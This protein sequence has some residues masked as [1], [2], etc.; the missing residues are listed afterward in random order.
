M[1]AV[2]KGLIHATRRP[3]FLAVA[4]NAQLYFHSGF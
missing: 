2:Y 1:A 3:A 4:I